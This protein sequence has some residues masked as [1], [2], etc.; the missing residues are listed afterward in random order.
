MTL[1]P[2]PSGHARPRTFGP[3]QSQGLFAGFP[4]WRRALGTQ[5]DTGNVG[6]PA[7]PRTRFIVFIYTSVLS[8]K[9]PRTS[10]CFP[11]CV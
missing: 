11:F 10:Q 2:P 8:L 1:H 3:M 7:L 5:R 6:G 4:P 9:E